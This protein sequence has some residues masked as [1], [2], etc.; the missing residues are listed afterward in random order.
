MKNKSIFFA[1]ALACAN[2][3]AQD[4][5]LTASQLDKVETMT[6]QGETSEVIAQEISSDIISNMTD[7]EIAAEKERCDKV[8]KKAKR[9]AFWGQVALSA[10]SQA[11]NTLSSQSYATARSNTPYG[12]YTTRIQYTNTYEVAQKNARD[13]ERFAGLGEQSIERDLNNAGCSAF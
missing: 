2:A 3:S 5:A 13:R 9:K 1:I 4:V 6:Q 8:F 12:R 10:V 11:G 7:A